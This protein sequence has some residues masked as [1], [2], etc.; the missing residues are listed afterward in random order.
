V[1][2]SYDL[3][4]FSRMVCTHVYFKSRLTE[5]ASRHANEQ[6]TAPEKV[7]RNS[8]PS[9][10]FRHRIMVENTFEIMKGIKIVNMQIFGPSCDSKSIDM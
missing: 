10:L 2:D 3:C 1:E 5:F 9:A 8:H 6:L 4:V 7:Y